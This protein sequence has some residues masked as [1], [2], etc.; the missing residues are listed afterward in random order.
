M[1]HSIYS[2]DELHI[3]T[4]V[5]FDHE[6]SFD[7]SGAVFPFEDVNGYLIDSK[8]EK[9]AQ[10]TYESFTF[11]G[12]YGYLI[13]GL[14]ETKRSQHVVMIKRPIRD[15]LQL[16]QEALIQWLVRKTLMPYEMETA[17]PQ[18]YDIFRRNGQSCFS[19]EYIRG[20]FPYEFIIKSNE[21]DRVFFQ[22]ISQLSLLCGI[23]QRDLH[24]DHRDLKMENLFIRTI[25]IRYS[26]SFGKNH[27][28]LE[29]PFQLVIFDFGFACLGNVKGVTQVNLAKDILP[30][31]DPCPKTGRDLFH[32]IA[33]FWTNPIFRDLM[34]MDTRAEVDSWF[35]SS[36]RDYSKIVK[37]FNNTEWV[38]VLTS[39][40]AFKHQPMD[41][42]TILS[43]IA[44]L[45]PSIL[46]LHV[47]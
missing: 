27:Y 3:F 32:C 17:V 7:L 15:Y 22:M 38:Y 18:V 34:S 12:G 5:S 2:L 31:L 23:L 36:K 42:E 40:A 8:K 41:C 24:F 11:Q 44:S 26:V 14:R 19:M 39:T 47:S 28:T 4:K 6:D 46:K 45:H 9:Y 35:I 20:V 25:P 13:K 1:V 30:Q 33:S 29:C 37:K 21:P 43:R 16:G 10:L